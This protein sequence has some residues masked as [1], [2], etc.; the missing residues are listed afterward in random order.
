MVNMPCRPARLICSDCLTLK[1]KATQSFETLVD[2]RQWT[3]RHVQ[4]DLN[5]QQNRCDKIKSRM[6]YLFSILFQIKMWSLNPHSTRV[7]HSSLEDV[8]GM[9]SKFCV[10][11]FFLLTMNIVQNHVSDVSHPPVFFIGYHRCCSDRPNCLDGGD[12]DSR[13]PNTVCGHVKNYGI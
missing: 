2:I 12:T 6:W 1:M 10:L 5:V 9:F 11:F 4:Q 13:V 7:H 3:R 8:S